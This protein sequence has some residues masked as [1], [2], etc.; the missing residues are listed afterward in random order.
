MTAIALTQHS[1]VRIQQRGL[2]IQDP[3][4][5]VLLGTPVEGGYLVR[6][7][8]CDEV[9]HAL[10]AV[11]RKVERLR[12][13]RVVM[14]GNRIVTVYRAR[15]ESRRKLIREARDCGLAD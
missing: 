5:I 2:S 4:L 13:Q 14:A 8:D 10:K 12:G 1:L 15:K 3:E 6:H 9:I 7:K 11:M